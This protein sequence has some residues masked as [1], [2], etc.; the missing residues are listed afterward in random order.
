MDP[1]G[2]FF[3]NTPANKRLSRDDARFVDVIHTNDQGIGN[4]D[5]IGHADFYPN[6]GYHQGGCDELDSQ[7]KLRQS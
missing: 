3:E 7:Y 6:G 4:S 1:A 2:P 5:V